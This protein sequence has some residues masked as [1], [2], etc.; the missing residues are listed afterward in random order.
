VS[1]D[2]LRALGVTP[3][4][5]RE[6][7]T[8]GSGGS[9]KGVMV[10]RKLADRLWPSESALGQTLLVGPRSDFDTII[11]ARSYEVVGVI[12]DG[13]FSG[14][15]REQPNFV[16]FS[17]E[18]DPSSPGESTFYVRSPAGV[19]ALAPAIRAAVRD[20]DPGTAIVRLRTLTSQFEQD[21]LLWPVRTLTILLTLFAS[22]S[23][24]IASIGQYAVVAFDMRRRVREFG[25]RIALGASASQVL[26]SVVRDGL[27]LTA[28]GLALGFTLSIAVAN[29]L[30]GFLYGITP[31]DAITYTGVF[32]L[33]GV[34]SLTAC[35][36]PAR[37]AAGIDP[38]TALRDE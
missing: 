22:L 31:T 27:R 23:L 21:S 34:A 25:L 5:G 14:Y 19:D 2:Y 1:A 37:R 8:Q 20:A 3:L 13:Y 11:P 33:L 32:A 12:P 15:R 35:F 24:L 29:A 7:D 16:F 18:Q 9:T 30:R 26:T 38:N 17:A 6:F 36:I 4:A 10:N 28:I